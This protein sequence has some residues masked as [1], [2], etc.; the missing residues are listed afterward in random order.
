MSEIKRVQ[1]Y[2]LTQEFCLHRRLR[3]AKTNINTVPVAKII[4]LLTAFVSTIELLKNTKHIYRKEI[5]YQH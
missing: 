1:F 3:N 4:Y 2:L 5:H